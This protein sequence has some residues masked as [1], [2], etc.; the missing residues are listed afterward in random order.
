MR[1][2]L[3]HEDLSRLATEM[4]VDYLLVNMDSR[5]VTVTAILNGDGPDTMQTVE[6]PRILLEKFKGDPV[7]M[8]REA[9]RL[10]GSWACPDTVAH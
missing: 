5:R 7:N 8:V 9:F 3:C 2:L 10:P 1:D 6:F 4:R